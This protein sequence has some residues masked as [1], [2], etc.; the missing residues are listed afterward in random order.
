MHC[1]QETMMT[2]MIT[3]LQDAVCQAMTKDDPDAV[4]FSFIDRIGAFLGAES[5]FL[6]DD[7]PI[8]FYRW[9]PD[10]LTYDEERSILPEARRKLRDWFKEMA[11]QGEP[12]LIGDTA[13]CPD[14]DPAMKVSMH[15]FHVHSLAA[16][17][18]SMPGN[19]IGAISLENIPPE[20]LERA[21][22]LLRLAGS[23]ILM[24]LKNRDHIYQLRNNSFIDQMTGVFN[25]NAFDAYQR[26]INCQVSMGVLFADI[27]NLKETND[28]EGHASG[29]R[30]ICQTASVLLK[31]CCGGEV[32]R[33]GGD[34]FVIIWQH[35]EKPD[36]QQA[37][38]QICRQFAVQDLN[39]AIG[40]HWVP[41][42]AQGM[43]PVLQ[44]ADKH[45][46][47]EKRRY[48]RRQVSRS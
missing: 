43:A 14:L 46:Y 21:G 40:H 31:Y 3:I 16:I 45:M 27:N 24:M 8:H 47:E 26:H 33:I 13:A 6:F 15:R 29:D 23:F 1:D 20:G 35:I 22:E 36:F 34:E 42:A 5:A 10:G 2:T 32:F 39:I 18:I 37:C 48:H 19:R 38:R 30:L 28:K 25:R 41:E 4:L 44:A 9:T 7:T 11:R 17:G 12:V